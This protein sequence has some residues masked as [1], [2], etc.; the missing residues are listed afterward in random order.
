MTATLRRSTR[1]RRVRLPSDSD[2]SGPPSLASSGD[3]EDSVR[4]ERCNDATDKLPAN[5][6]RLSRESNVPGTPPKR[7]RALAAPACDGL[8]SGD[9][10]SEDVTHKTREREKLAGEQPI[11]VYD[12][13]DELMDHILEHVIARERPTDVYQNIIVKPTPAQESALLRMGC[14]KL[15]LD[16]VRTVRDI[17]D[18]FAKHR[19]KPTEQQMNSL[20]NR[21]IPETKLRLITTR[22]M[23][24]D[25]ICKARSMVCA[26]YKQMKLIRTLR[27]DANITSEMP[28]NLREDEATEYI[29]QLKSERP[30]TDAMVRML[31]DLGVPRDEIPKSHTAA[32]VMTNKLLY[33]KNARASTKS[34]R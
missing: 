33:A 8:S 16:L 24:S 27:H 14:S 7:A 17:D 4:I 21:G 19:N 32:H 6:K 31:S 2:V 28:V 20:R 1:K 13:N 10:A 11:Q 25:L 12:H 5:D 3:E 23:A 22:Q 30:P 18:L 34:E 9:L 26:S 29:Q 15:E